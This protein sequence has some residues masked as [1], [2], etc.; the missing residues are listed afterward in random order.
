MFTNLTNNIRAKCK[1]KMKGEKLFL[2][3]KNFVLIFFLRVTRNFECL[4]FLL[5][6]T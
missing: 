6:F 2:K 1:C 3:Q 4:F 5:I